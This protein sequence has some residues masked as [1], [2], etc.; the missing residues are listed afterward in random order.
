[1]I[2]EFNRSGISFRYPANWLV[3]AEKSE[4]TAWTVSVH[5]PATAFILFSLRPDA[6]DPAD[7]ADQ[8][9]EALKAEYKELDAEN[10]L[11]TIAGQLSIGHDI[12][13]LTVDT[14][15]SCRS[16]CLETPSGPLLV[17][18]QTADFDRE[19]NDPV[20]RAIVAS[21]KVEEE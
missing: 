18:C 8:T 15:I 14:P 4:E 2:S 6:R 9:L 11:E 1:V 10:R 13:F 12:D 20:L 19:Q 3:E 5:S 7:L 16:R 21:L 17:L